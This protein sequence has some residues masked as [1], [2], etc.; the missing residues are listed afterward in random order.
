VRA[1]DRVTFSGRP[2]WI[3]REAFL[4]R[5]LWL[6]TCTYT[7]IR[8]LPRPAFAPLVE[9]RS[10]QFNSLSVR[11]PYSVPNSFRRLHD[12]VH[13]AEQPARGRRGSLQPIDPH[14]DGEFLLR[15]AIGPRPRLATEHNV[16]DAPVPLAAE[17]AVL[18]V[19]ICPRCDRVGE[20]KTPAKP[21]KS[22]A[23]SVGGATLSAVRTAPV[24]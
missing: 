19:F 7:H 8:P 11:C 20:T 9:Q 23:A 5:R 16:R 4:A 12:Q 21:L 3:S 18:H 24:V 22:K 2:A 14:I 15:V 13:H 17:Q 6:L 10:I 1:F